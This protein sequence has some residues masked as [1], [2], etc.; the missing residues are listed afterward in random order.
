MQILVF[1]NVH[2]TT[3]LIP[4]YAST[5]I[6]EWKHKYVLGITRSLRFQPS[7]PLRFWKNCILTAGYLINRNPSPL[8]NNKPLF[9]V[10]FHKPPF[11]YHLRVFGCPF[12][13]SSFPIEDKF[14]PRANACVF[15]AYSNIQKCYK[16]TDLNTKRFLFIETL[17]SWASIS[18]WSSSSF[19]FLFFPRLHLSW[20]SYPWSF[21]IFI[22]TSG[23][24]SNIP[25]SVDSC[26]SP[27]V[28][29]HMKRSSWTIQRPH[30]LRIIHFLPLVLILFQIIYH[31]PSFTLSIKVS[32]LRYNPSMSHDFTMRQLLIL[33]GTKLSI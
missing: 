3:K 29:P 14:S 24:S 27:H 28:S 20:L 4:L 11:Y 5:K 32:W 6:M 19:Q 12:D 8:L 33:D 22:A 10:L 17:I 30:E 9:E 25:I 21:W 1:F 23:D 7:L 15:L 13:D 16:V 2:Y 26:S 18:I 31:I